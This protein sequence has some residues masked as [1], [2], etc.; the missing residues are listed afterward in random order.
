MP[1]SSYRSTPMS[2]LWLTDRVE[3]AVSGPPRTASGPVRATAGQE[4]A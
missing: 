2:P 1:V 3:H 4:A